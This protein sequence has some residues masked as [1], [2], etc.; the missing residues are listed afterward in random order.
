MLKDALRYPRNRENAWT[1]PIL[2]GGFVYFIGNFVITLPF[3]WG[4][5]IRVLDSTIEG[6]PEPPEFANWKRLYITGM[7]PTVIVVLALLIPFV[8]LGLIAES[9]TTGAAAYPMM[10]A[11]IPVFAIFWYVVPAILGNVAYSGN[12]RGAL[13]VA[14][15]LSVVGNRRYFTAWALGT[16]VFFGTLIA[17]VALLIIPLLGALIFF[18][19][20][21]FIMFYAATASFYL[22]GRGY[23]Y[24]RNITPV[25]AK[26]SPNT[27]STRDQDIKRSTGQPP[28]GTTTSMEEIED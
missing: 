10:V 12:A 24:A 28:K 16:I 17:L 8:F 4:Y 1:N 9:M 23:A 20:G 11:L 3:Y 15:T 21:A 14:T 27:G 19:G 26:H 18:F 6:N 2:V 7:V 25:T 13:D 5:L 22:Y